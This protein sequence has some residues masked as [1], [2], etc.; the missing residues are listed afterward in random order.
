MLS[1]HDTG[2]CTRLGMWHFLVYHLAKIKSSKNWSIL[3]AVIP[4]GGNQNIF[5][6]N[7]RLIVYI[8]CK[9]YKVTVLQL[10]YV[11]LLL[12]L[13]IILM[14]SLQPYFTIHLFETG[15]RL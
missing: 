14:I 6:K 4:T 2:T 7:H 13:I 3:V 8:E 9:H 15:G 5:I 10:S 12:D 11:E 1:L